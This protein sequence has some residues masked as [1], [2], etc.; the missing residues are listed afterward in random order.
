MTALAL[1]VA[2]GSLAPVRHAIAAI[3]PALVPLALWQTTEE[4]RAKKAAPQAQKPSAP[5]AASQL[6]TLLGWENLHFEE[7]AFGDAAGFADAIRRRGIA[8]AD[9][10]RIVS[11]MTGLVDFRRCRPSDTVALGRDDKGRLRALAYRRSLRELYEARASSVP[12]SSPANGNA[13]KASA[14]AP[15]WSARQVELP[16]TRHRIVA[17]GVIAAHQSL[18]RALDAAGLGARVAGLF[19][20]LFQGHVN[21]SSDLRPGDRFRVM[22]VEERLLGERV[23]HRM[24]ELLEYRG[25]TTGEL[26]AY[27]YHP[28]GA[29]AGYYDAQGRSLESREFRTPLAYTHISSSYNP[30]RRHP[31]LKRIVP[32]NGVDLAAG[33]GAPIYATAAGRVS[34]VGRRGANGNLVVVEH[35]AGWS[36]Y[37]AHLARFA[38]G[39]RPG[40]KVRAQQLIGYVGSTGRSTGPHLHFA[41][42]RNGVFVDPMTKLRASGN[43]LPQR[44]RND[45][46]QLR[47]ELVRHSRRTTTRDSPMDERG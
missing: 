30:R 16:I 1:V 43:P 44:Y 22:V 4:P 31:I 10:D 45:F 21:F 47:S 20:R 26:K 34:F 8:Q 7:G 5:Q 2:S 25:A 40:D 14:A 28:P 46:R 23:G 3:H 35:R 24:P 37:Y 39:L 15:R 17:K 42:K 18:A 12:D 9:A 19:Q 33:H 6:E 41:L 36:S 29:T 13:G 11:A 32:H 27:R 38:R